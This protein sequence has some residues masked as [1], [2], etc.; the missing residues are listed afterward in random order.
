MEKDTDLIRSFESRKKSLKTPSLASCIRAG[1][2]F[3]PEIPPSSQITQG[4]GGICHRMTDI[5]LETKLRKNVQ[6]PFAIYS[7][8]KPLLSYKAINLI[9]ILWLHLTVTE[10]GWVSSCLAEDTS[11]AKAQWRASDWSRQQICEATSAGP[12]RD[13]FQ[14]PHG[15]R[16]NPLPPTNI[17]LWDLSTFK[18]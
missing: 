8:V 10:P 13:I 2:A 11:T 14:V 7:S 15:A 16:S 5:K 18:W 12:S 6:D 17:F 4:W 1:C 9:P 3:H